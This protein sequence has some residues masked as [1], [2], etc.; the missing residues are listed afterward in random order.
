VT[1]TYD[2]LYS[3]F[4]TAFPDPNS[5]A[6]QGTTMYVPISPTFS[7]TQTMSMG[8]VGMAI[9]GVFIY[10]SVAGNTDNI[11]AEGGSFDQCGGHPDNA[12]AYHY[13]GEPY[14]ISYQ[15]DNLIGV[16]M[17]G[18]FVY[19]R[20][21]NTAYAADYTSGALINEP[22]SIANN[23][24]DN[25]GDGLTGSSSTLYK[26]GGHVGV[27]PTGGTSLFHYHL[28]EWEGCYDEVSPGGTKD[29]DD[30]EID[31]TIDSNPSPGTCSIGGSAYFADTWFLTGHGNGGVYNTIPAGLHGQIPSQTLTAVRYYYGTPGSCTNCP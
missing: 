12:D 2:S 17:D 14:S 7:G 16:M 29:A 26:Y 21:D 6:A 15:D 30:G 10:D 18:F 20:N 13:H 1:G 3:A 25:N 4:T 31:D 11:F 28:T 9:N 5:I 27:P 23:Y 22:G 8:T 19:G 24:N